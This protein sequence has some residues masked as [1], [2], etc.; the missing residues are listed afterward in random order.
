MYQ[1]FFRVYASMQNASGCAQTGLSASGTHAA[2]NS[3]MQ[4]LVPV[5]LFVDTSTYLTLPPERKKPASYSAL[6]FIHSWLKAGMGCEG[7][8]QA[9]HTYGV[10]IVDPNTSAPTASGSNLI[11][12]HILPLVANSS[13]PH[14][15]LC[16]LF[17]FHTAASRPSSAKR[18]C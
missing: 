6:I 5:C 17:L 14:L 7:S 13:L 10:A 9:K 8:T 18:H 1:G 11:H 15:L 2:C 3:S 4:V 16:S 12:P